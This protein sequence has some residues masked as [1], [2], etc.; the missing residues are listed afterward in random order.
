LHSVRLYDDIS[1]Y[2]SCPCQ[3]EGNLFT[4][5]GAGSAAEAGTAADDS[6]PD[7]EIRLLNMLIGNSPETMSQFAQISNIDAQ[8]LIL[9]NP[10]TALLLYSCSLLI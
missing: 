4:R 2:L 6:A 7:V 1:G 10:Y 8:V 9:L 3:L 5:V